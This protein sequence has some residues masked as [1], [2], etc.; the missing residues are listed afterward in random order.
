MNFPR[1]IFGI[2]LIFLAVI[3]LLISVFALVQVWRLRLP[4]ATRIYDG[5]LVAEKIVETTSSG[6]DV[7]DDSLTNVKK[8]ITTLEESTLTMAQSMQDTSQLIDSFSDLFKGDL[9]KTLENTKISVVAAQSSALI[10]DNLLYG[11][12]RIPILGIEYAPPKPLNKALKEIGETLTDMPDSMDEISGS[13]SE[14][15]VTLL[16]LKTGIDEIATSFAGFQADLSAAQTVVNDYQSNMREIKSSLD[17][18]Q[19]KIFNWSIWVAINLTITIIAIAVAQ[20][21]AILQGYEMMHYQQSLENLIEKK[22]R[23]LEAQ[24]LQSEIV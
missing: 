13:L 24:K 12:S 15:N 5:L 6:L 1:K 2:G 10:I 7:I 14:S 4:V 17:N 22:I 9:K 20:V 18:A 21:A 3:G 23:E 11:L 16:S 8:S 19:E